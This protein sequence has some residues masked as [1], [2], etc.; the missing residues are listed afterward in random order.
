MHYLDALAQMVSGA[1][2]APLLRCAEHGIGSADLERL[3]GQ[4]LESLSLPADA[5]VIST[6]PERFVV[7]Q[8]HW[9]SLRERALRALRDFH[10]QTPEEAGP[11]VGRLR[12]IA[13]PALAHPRWLA[14][15]DELAREQALVRVGAWLRLPEHAV[16]LSHQEEALGKQLLPLLAAGRFD[17]P[18]VRNLAATVRAPEDSVRRVLQKLLAQGSVHQ[19]VRD[20]FYD[21]ACIGELADVAA[22]LTREHER[23]EV[24][25]YRDAI[26]LGRKRTIQILE[27]FDRVGYTRRVRDWRILRSDRG[28]WNAVSALALAV[29]AAPIAEPPPHPVPSPTRGEGE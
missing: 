25:D 12:R 14:L 10:M 19:I 1:G 6:A 18:W 7:L 29:I 4:P 21:H 24:A 5:R 2:V 17:P 23:I 13:A 11:D 26:G 27:F 9:H 15:I 16:A 8:A 22:T 28:G 20:L 3:S